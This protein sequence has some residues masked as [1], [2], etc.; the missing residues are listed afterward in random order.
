MHIS[1]IH[2]L[3]WKG[4]VALGQGT[5]TEALLFAVFAALKMAGGN[6]EQLEL[7]HDVLRIYTKS[8]WLLRLENGGTWGG[9]RSWGQPSAPCS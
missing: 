5:K 4:G 9:K 8:R 6:G 7:T 3:I 1:D 2:G